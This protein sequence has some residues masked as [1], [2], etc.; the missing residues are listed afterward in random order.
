VICLIVSSSL[1]AS[2]AH[3]FGLLELMDVYSDVLSLG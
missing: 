1:V 2:F 3:Y